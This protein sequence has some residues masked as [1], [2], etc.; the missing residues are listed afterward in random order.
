MHI[1][2]AVI[3]FALAITFRSASARSLAGVNPFDS[4]S[5]RLSNCASSD[6]SQTSMATCLAKYTD[7][8]QQAENTGNRAGECGALSNYQNCMCHAA[9]QCG[10]DT[11]RADIVAVLT[12]ATNDICNN[13]D[14]VSKYKEAGATCINAISTLCAEEKCPKG[15]F[16]DISPQ[17]ATALAEQFTQKD[18]ALPTT[19]DGRTFIQALLQLQG[20]TK[21]TKFVQTEE[22]ITGG[23][24]VPSCD[25]P[26]N[27]FLCNKKAPGGNEGAATPPPT[28]IGDTSQY[29]T[30]GNIDPADI[31]GIK[32]AYNKQTDDNGL[33]PSEDAPLDPTSFCCDR[34]LRPGICES[35]EIKTGDETKKSFQCDKRWI[36]DR[37]AAFREMCNA[38]VDGTQYG[39]AWFLSAKSEL[40]VDNVRWTQSIIDANVLCFPRVCTSADLQNHLK[41]R[42][43]ECT[44]NFMSKCTYTARPIECNVGSIDCKTRGTV[45]EQQW[46]NPSDPAKKW[47]YT[48]CDNI[49]DNIE[50]C[51]FDTSSSLAPVEMSASFATWLRPGFFTTFATISVVMLTFV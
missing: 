40:Q 14:E 49:M 39:D 21:Q 47:G 19:A 35:Q 8:K 44:K 20:L 45:G 50:T 4:P 13:P 24:W 51:V 33:C 42:A 28:P 6:L 26:T 25:K 37:I 41:T 36:Y 10:D 30:C 38:N 15:G 3:F 9:D 11:G 16:G 22:T 29:I 1:N 34:P 17:C 23:Y 18:S 27:S 43:Q 32:T 7:E 46:N 5:R 31:Q 12:T 2:T 48:T